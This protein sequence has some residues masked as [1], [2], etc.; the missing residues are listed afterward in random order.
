LGKTDD[1]FA[2]PTQRLA[3]ALARVNR[4][5]SV[6]QRPA[7]TDFLFRACR[8]QPSFGKSREF[9]ITTRQVDPLGSSTAGDIDE[10][11]E[12]EGY[13]NGTPSFLAK[14]DEKLTIR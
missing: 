1:G 7:L 11:D 13:V 6:P 14:E 4:P 8:K 2:S 5:L 3:D 10:D 9:E 12:D